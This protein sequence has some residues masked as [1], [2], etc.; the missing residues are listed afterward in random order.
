MM[1]AFMAVLSFVSFAAFVLAGLSINRPA[2]IEKMRELAAQAGDP[3]IQAQML[4][5]TGDPGFA[6]FTAF[7]LFFF[8]VFF[9]IVAMASGALLAGSK[10]SAPPR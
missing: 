5:F 9:L 3:K 8:L 7:T 10:T 1:G 2:V 6:V 4:W